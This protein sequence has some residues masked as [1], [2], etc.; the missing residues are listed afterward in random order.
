MI[1]L[2]KEVW[3]DDGVVTT[4]YFELDALTVYAVF[5]ARHGID[6]LDSIWATKAQAQAKADGL[7]YEGRA[8]F[9]REFKAFVEAI[10]VQ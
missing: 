5:T 10:E 7:E 4:Y 1:E 3:G 9:D 6:T 8:Q 2:E